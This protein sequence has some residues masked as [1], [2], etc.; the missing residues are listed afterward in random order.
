M[1]ANNRREVFSLIR[2]ARFASQRR[3]KHISAEVNQHA[4]IE[5]AMFSMRAAPKLYNEDPTQV[6]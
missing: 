5:E 2:A 4:T 6:E 3:G 1:H